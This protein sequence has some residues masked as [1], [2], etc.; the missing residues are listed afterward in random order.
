MEGK[1]GGNRSLVST[2]GMLCF[3][4]SGP[5]T[6]TASVAL[7]YGTVYLFF[8]TILNLTNYYYAVMEQM[9]SH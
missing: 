4:H 6:F 9:M 5:L 3:R 1:G 8:V 7:G 2:V